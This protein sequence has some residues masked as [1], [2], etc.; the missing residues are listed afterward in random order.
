MEA[1]NN[2]VVHLVAYAFPENF[3]VQD[4]VSEIGGIPSLVDPRGLF[5][6]I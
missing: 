5:E 2:P 3:A 1:S 6:R 4:L